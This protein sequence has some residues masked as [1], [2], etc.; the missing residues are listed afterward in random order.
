MLV[1]GVKTW[2]SYLINLVFLFICFIE[3]FEGSDMCLLIRKSFVYIPVNDN[4]DFEPILI[5]KYRLTSFTVDLIH[6]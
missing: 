6:P 3:S 4:Y 5:L 2:R 1:C